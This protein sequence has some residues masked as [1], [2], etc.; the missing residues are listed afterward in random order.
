MS[1]VVTLKIFVLSQEEL[2][3]IK[4]SIVKGDFFFFLMWT[5]KKK[6]FIFDWAGSLLLHVDFL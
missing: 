6:L 4:K 2:P 5:I 1:S 3:F